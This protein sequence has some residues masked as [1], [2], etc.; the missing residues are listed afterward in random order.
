MDEGDQISEE[1]EQETDSL[2]KDSSSINKQDTVIV[3]EVDNLGGLLD[4]LKV[5]TKMSVFRKM[6]REQVA[7]LIKPI[8]PD[9]STRVNSHISKEHVEVSSDYDI[10]KPSLGLPTDS[11]QTINQQTINQQSYGLSQ[12]PMIPQ[13]DDII[14][15]IPS[16]LKPI[17]Y[18]GKMVYTDATIVLRCML[19]HIHTYLLDGISQARCK[20]CNVP[21]YVRCKREFL[22]EI[23]ETPFMVKT[24]DTNDYYH[25]YCPSLKIIVYDRMPNDL[26]EGYKYISGMSIGSILQD[27]VPYMSEFSKRVQSNVRAR[28]APRPQ[29]I[30]YRMTDLSAR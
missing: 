14:K 17:N 2:S 8:V 10:D 4:D 13:L 23:F 29:P 24:N 9:P 15:M 3:Q 30:F 22:E 27:L 19:Y 25:I 7:D 28:L 18:E 26:I 5:G 20:S 11:Q 16:D 6:W 12:V 21:S 1:S